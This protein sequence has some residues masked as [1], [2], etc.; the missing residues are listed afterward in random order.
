MSEAEAAAA[1]AAAAQRKL[2]EEDAE[3][4]ASF[5]IP[6]WVRERNAQL[7]EELRGELILAPLTRANHVPFRKFLLELGCKVT[8][9]EMAFGKPLVK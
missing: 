2:E 9:S 3:L 8:M 4:A 1:D 5:Q 6:D 7:V